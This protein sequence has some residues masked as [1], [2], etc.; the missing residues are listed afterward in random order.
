V[1]HNGALA[2][3]RITE[4]ND[5]AGIIGRRRD[6]IFDYLIFDRMGRQFIFDFLNCLNGD[7]RWSEWRDERCLNLQNNL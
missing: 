1:V 6:F 5:F 2:N 3:C 7:V 4:K